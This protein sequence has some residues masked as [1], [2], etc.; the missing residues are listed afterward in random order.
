MILSGTNVRLFILPIP[1]L[2]TLS[3]QDV[4]FYDHK[5]FFFRPSSGVPVTR[6]SPSKR[7]EEGPLP[8]SRGPGHAYRFP[9]SLSST[10]TTFIHLIPHGSAKKMPTELVKTLSQNASI[11]GRN[12]GEHRVFTPT[13]LVIL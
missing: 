12:I 10:F 7:P 13:I 11:V 5:I 4:P 8:V 2:F 3:A 1:P 6:R 9:T